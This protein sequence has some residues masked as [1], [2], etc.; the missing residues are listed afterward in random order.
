LQNIT[1][2]KFLIVDDDAVDIMA[3]QRAIKKLK[4]ANPILV[5]K[6]GIEALEIIRGEAGYERPMP[7]FI[8][9]LDLNMPRMN[10]Q[11]FLDQLRKDEALR[12][13]VVFVWSSSDSP[14]DIDASYDH[15]VA[16]YIV[17]E[18]GEE[19]FKRALSML[20]EYSQVVVLPNRPQQTMH[21]ARPI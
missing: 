6:D 9:M 12:S 8:V 15:N 5:A 3:I 18:N 2:V 1:P 10:G 4:L 17:K 13:V 14:S 11:E 19:T 21:A 16:G 20:D 7:P